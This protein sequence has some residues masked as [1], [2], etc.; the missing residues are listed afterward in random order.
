[1]KGIRSIEI[2]KLPRRGT[3]KTWRIGFFVRVYV[4]SCDWSLFLCTHTNKTK[5]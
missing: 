3:W 5:C 4:I 2:L 1:L